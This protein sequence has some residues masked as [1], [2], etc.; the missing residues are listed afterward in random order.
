[1]TF[2]TEW[3][4]KKPRSTSLIFIDSIIIWFVI[5]QKLF[6]ILVASSFILVAIGST[7]QAD[8]V[9]VTEDFS[10]GAGSIAGWTSVGTFTT[11]ILHSTS[12]QD[13]DKN[14][15]LSPVGNEA[16]GDG[17]IGDG[18]LR[19]NTENAIRGDEAIAFT[20]GGTMSL[21]ESIT[22]DMNLF[23][24]NSSYH[25]ADYQLFN[26]T[27]GT[28]LNSSGLTLVLGNTHGSYVPTDIQVSYTALATDVGDTLQIRIIEDNNDTSRDVYVDNFSVTSIPEPSSFAVFSIGVVAV[29]LRRRQRKTRCMFK[30]LS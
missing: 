2:P 27:D 7:I 18:A 21:G 10:S 19:F 1:M 28:V 22:L 24:G 6:T 4:A 20:L 12:N 30:S 13:F 15:L 3:N 5:M 16:T 25:N 9:F 17:V 8:I 26:L 23:N 11:S 14:D 29:L